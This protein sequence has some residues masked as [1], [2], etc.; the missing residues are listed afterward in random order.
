MVQDG[1]S[2][3]STG[4]CVATVKRLLQTTLRGC[5]NQSFEV[6]IANLTAALF[7]ENSGRTR[8]FYRY[9]TVIVEARISKD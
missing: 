9:V 2:T 4:G 7:W 3:T 8:N 5:Y 6:V 1:T